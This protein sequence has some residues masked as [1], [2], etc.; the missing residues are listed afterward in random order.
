M[1]CGLETVF[2]ELWKAARWGPCRA[3]LA[4]LGK[5]EIRGVGPRNG[6]TGRPLRETKVK[7]PWAWKFQ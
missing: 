6:A 7:H 5:N 3:G 1:D 2:S 4:I